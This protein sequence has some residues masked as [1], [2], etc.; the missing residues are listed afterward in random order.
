M[1]ADEPGREAAGRGRIPG[2]AVDLGA[3][4][5]DVT[6]LVKER[7]NLRSIIDGIMDTIV[8]VVP[9][10]VLEQVMDAGKRTI[11]ELIYSIRA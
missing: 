9:K 1:A 11:D 3:L 10:N 8:Q 6:E 7:L 4:L 2:P 5:T